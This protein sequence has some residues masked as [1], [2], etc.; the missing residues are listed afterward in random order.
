MR[1]RVVHFE[2]AAQD[3]ER[4]AEF[5]RQAFGW[6]IKKWDGPVEYWMVM[7]GPQGQMGIDGGILRHREGAPKTVNTIGV[8]S[9]DEAVERVVRSGGQVV[10]PKMA[11]P[12]VGYQ[13][14]CTDTEGILF[15]LHEPNPAAK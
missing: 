9:V 10:A 14:Y 6:D 7:T 3:P 15:G 1:E 11:I 13:A 2:L 4:A 8:A 5:Y 12:G